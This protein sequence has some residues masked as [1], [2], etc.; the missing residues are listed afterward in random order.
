M[1]TKSEVQK[2][3][4]GIL[5]TE[6]ELKC[7]KENTRN[8]KPQQIIRLTN[9]NSEQGKYHKN[10]KTAGIT[11]Y[12]VMLILN[13]NSY[14]SLT[15]RHRMTGWIKKQDSSIFCLP[16]MHLTD[17]KKFWL[18]IRDGKRFP[19]KTHPQ[20]RQGSQYLYLIK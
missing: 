5:H 20:N 2:T 1:T 18:G 16:E 14:S 17:K 7:N 10:N 9:E 19:K 4:I 11:T 3:L 8:D 13:F 15:R 12:R 6:E